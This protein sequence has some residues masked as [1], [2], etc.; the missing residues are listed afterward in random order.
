MTI[1]RRLLFLFIW[2]VFSIMPLFPQ[3][4]DLRRVSP[5]SQGISSSD[6]K[7]YF[8][9][10]L[11]CPT[12]EPHGIMILRH[13]KVVG[14][15]FPKPFDGAYSQMLYSVSKTFV[16]VAVGLAIEENRL[17]LTDRV[18]VFFPELL[19]DSISDY[20]ADMT[21]RDLLTMTAGVQP[22]P[23]MRTTGADWIRRYLAK[24][25]AKPGEVF[26]YDS[27]CSYLLS[28]IVQRVT[29]QKLLEYL[30]PRIFEPMHIVEV[31]WEESPEGINTGGWGLRM[32]VESMAKF[33]QL[34]LNKGNWEGKQLISPDWV[35]EMTSSLQETGMADTY[36][37]HTWRCDY[38]NAY[39][40]DGALGQYIIV[41]P[42]EDMVVAI[43]QANTSN[44][45]A[46]RQIVWKLLREV[47]REPLP[48]SDAYAT[49]LHTQRSCSLPLAQ[50]KKRVR[51]LSFIQNK[52]ISLGANGLDWKSLRFEPGL[53]D[54]LRIIITT[55]SDEEFTLLAGLGEW[56]T[57]RTDAC[58][59]YAI[60]AIGRF[61][62]IHPPF[63][64]A[65]CYGGDNN[66]LNLKVRYTNWG[67]G[68]DIFL[69]TEKNQ[70]FLSF[71]ENGKRNA[72]DVVA[73]ME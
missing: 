12:G 57:T 28:A 7:R 39:R 68:A 5:E 53:K 50:A 16:G 20:L 55:A 6:I 35:E 1:Y 40:A 26:H 44:G 8:D 70:L 48:E 69:R 31:D 15:L 27:M 3:W 4:G 73:K 52:Q 17:K 29:G 21:V 60:K 11:S 32:H 24:P 65:G 72:Y 46:E 41:A 66:S 33:G 13:G 14:E 54:T 30:R 43:T 34:L 58:P 19:P 18:A 59:P 36:G 71:K 37:F 67:S 42:D 49:L 10:M 9:A 63:Y 38:P 47:K 2:G 45:V 22:D 25:I 51:C 56:L 23:L 62:G 61:Q 64:V